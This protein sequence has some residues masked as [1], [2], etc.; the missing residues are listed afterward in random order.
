M[1][2]NKGAGFD[3]HSCDYVNPNEF[4]DF[5]NHILWYSSVFEVFKMGRNIFAGQEFT[6]PEMIES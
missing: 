3:T 2:Q 4:C 1:S 5:D 6:R